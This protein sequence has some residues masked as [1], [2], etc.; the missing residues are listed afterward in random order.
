MSVFSSTA[1]KG[2][3]ALITGATGGIGSETAKQLVEMGAAVTITGRREAK[4][5]LLAKEIQELM[6]DAKVFTTTAD[7][8]KEEDRNQLVHSS[9]NALGPISLLV[10]NAGI[11]GGGRVE[12]LNQEEMERMMHVNYTS[13]VLLTQQIY[14]TMKKHNKGAIVNVASLSGLRGTHGNTAYAASKFALIG[15]THSMAVEAI[16]HGVRV[17]AVCPGYVDTEM[18]RSAAERKAT[19]ENRTVTE[20]IS[21]SIPSGRMTTAKE[22]ASTIAFLLTDAA[23]NIVGESVKISGGSVLR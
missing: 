1:L 7:I 8:G 21:G 3:H 14:K 15:F 22:V 20:V 11:V 23:E 6:T 19:R 10:N 17:N 4:L 16:A 2:E 12:E 5:K 9:E 18:G 13:T